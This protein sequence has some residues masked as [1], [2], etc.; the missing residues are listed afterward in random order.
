MLRRLSL[1]S[2]VNV[3]TPA[4]PTA[5]PAHEGHELPPD[6]DFPKVTLDDFPGEPI[7]LAVLPDR[8]PPSWTPA[9][10]APAT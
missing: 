4:V 8:S 9:T 7:A 6:S 3:A 5:A 1:I 10:P 2:V